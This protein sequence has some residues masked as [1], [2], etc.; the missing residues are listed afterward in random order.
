M[1]MVVHDINYHL[2]PDSYDW[3]FRTWYRLASDLAAKKADLVFTVSEYSKRTLVNHVGVN[4]DKVFVFQQGPGLPIKYLTDRPSEEV[5]RRPFILCVGSL[6][7]HKNLARILKAYDLLRT[8]NRTECELLVVGKKQNGFN[9]V[10][11]DAKYQDDPDIRFTGYLSDEELGQLYQQAE[12]F[13]FPSLEEG[14]GMPIV[15]AFYAGCPVVTS[16]CSC[17]PEIAGDAA[18]LVD[19]RDPESIA[20]GIERAIADNIFRH[21]L[22]NRG[23]DRAILYNWPNAATQVHRELV[24]LEESRCN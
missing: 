19:P 20:D 5:P 16:N 17:M 7:P 2:S 14:F 3:R 4:P 9:D 22:V 12:A 1:A 8:Q 13:V 21:E 23:R 6:Q 24:R 18:I 10:T 15:E 11:I